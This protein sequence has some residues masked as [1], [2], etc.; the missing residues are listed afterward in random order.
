MGKFIVDNN[1]PLLVS[2][3]SGDITEKQNSLHVPSNAK[4]SFLKTQIESMYKKQ[5]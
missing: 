1:K 5:V 4:I 2:G 3:L